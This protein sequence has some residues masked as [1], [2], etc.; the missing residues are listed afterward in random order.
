MRFNLFLSLILATLSLAR[1]DRLGGLLRRD[2]CTDNSEIDC[3]QSCMPVGSICCNDGSSTYCDAGTVCIPG[4]CCPVG[5]QCSGPGG[6]ET[7]LLTGTGALPTGGPVATTAGN[8]GPSNV[9]TVAPLDTS[10]NLAGGSTPK[11][12]STKAGTSA[13]HTA[14]SAGSTAAT[15][16][17][18]GAPGQSRGSE[19]YAIMVIA[20]GQLLLM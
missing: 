7:F 2:L 6:T 4:G 11:T 15:Q 10:T 8:G 5:Q 3:E 16:A 14:A 20:V 1:P 17:T 13:A 18:G 19:L 9:F 12:S